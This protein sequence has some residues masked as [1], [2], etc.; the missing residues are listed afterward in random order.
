MPLFDFRCACGAQ[1]E[2]LLGSWADPDPPCPRCALPTTRLPGR[3]AVLGGARPPKGDAG[4][5]TSFEGTRNGDREYIAHWRRRLDTRRE[6][7][8]R[9]PEHA[10]RREAIAAHEGAFSTQPLTYKEL[11]GRA[12][13]TGDATAAAAEA[14]QARKAAPAAPPE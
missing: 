2:H 9:N 1:F 4:A 5:P 14:S 7:E 13:S 11:A 12:A 6:F 10:T 3:I 8:E